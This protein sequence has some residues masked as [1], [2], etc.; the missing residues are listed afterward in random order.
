[1]R[2]VGGAGWGSFVVGAVVLLI[3]LRRE[4]STMRVLR[5][6]RSSRGSDAGSFGSDAFAGSDLRDE[7]WPGGAGPAASP[8][9]AFG[10]ARTYKGR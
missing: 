8:P 6:R 5:M 3:R 1:M 10:G 7:V 4:P 9:S 2:A